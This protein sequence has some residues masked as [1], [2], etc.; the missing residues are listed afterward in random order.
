[1]PST[2]CSAAL[3]K[4]GSGNVCDEVSSIALCKVTGAIHFSV[5]YA[6]FIICL[7]RRITHRCRNSREG[8][9][10]NGMLDHQASKPVTNTPQGTHM[11]DR[12]IQ[13]SALMCIR[14]LAKAQMPETTASLSAPHSTARSNARRLFMTRRGQ[15]PERGKRQRCLALRIARACLKALSGETAAY[16]APRIAG[17]AKKPKREKRRR[18]LAL[19]NAAPRIARAKAKMAGRHA[20]LSTPQVRFPLRPKFDFRFGQSSICT[21]AKVRFALRPKFDC[22]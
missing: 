3:L 13:I 10:G 7:N 15:N 20:L 5:R 16:A 6:I 14:N 4:T 1:L 2:L 12:Q 22:G 19:R 8:K 18:C 17:H 11:F 21:S 9:R